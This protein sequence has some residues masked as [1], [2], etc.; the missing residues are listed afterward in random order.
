MIALRIRRAALPGLLLLAAACPASA[1]PLKGLDTAAFRIYHKMVQ[2][3]LKGPWADFGVGVPS[4]SLKG[5]ATSDADKKKIEEWLKTTFVVQPDGK[6]VPVE[7]ASASYYSS[8]YQ[9]NDDYELDINY[10]TP[11]PAKKLTI[12]AKFSP[13]TVIS[14]GGSQFTLS[15]ES[16]SRTFDTNANLDNLFRNL[17]DFMWMGMMHLFTGFDHILFI[18]TLIFAAMNVK[19]VIKL[20]TAFTIGH[21]ITLVLTTFDVFRV[22]PRLVDIGI[23]GTI[24]FVALENIIRRET[25]QKQRWLIVFAFGLIHGM[26]FS[27]AL[28]EMGLPQHGLVL[29]LLSFNLGIEL[30]QVIIVCLIMPVLLRM[31]WVKETLRGD[32]GRREFGR[33][34]NWGPACTAAIGAYWLVARVMGVPI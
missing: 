34:L 32:Y 28:R 16:P 13:Q 15:A 23:A 27:A 17:Q 8:A 18:C 21:A 30:A 31:Q 7:I 26:G 2:C 22:N 29:C 10:A 25:P 11:A 4:A 24:V 33:L 3:T 14:V 19:S 9:N 5:E 6:T 12:T 20:L 1:H